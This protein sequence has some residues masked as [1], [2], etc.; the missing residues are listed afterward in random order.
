MVD[1]DVARSVSRHELSRQQVTSRTNSLSFCRG[2]DSYPSLHDVVANNNLHGSNRLQNH[3]P[4]NPFRHLKQ[5]RKHHSI[6]PS[7]QATQHVLKQTTE[8]TTQQTRRPP[9]RHVPD[10]YCQKNHVVKR[11]FFQNLPIPIIIIP[12]TFILQHLAYIRFFLRAL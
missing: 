1:T 7:H 9:S 11:F 12:F 4:L 5:Q 8:Q 6:R 2:A 3:T 10:V